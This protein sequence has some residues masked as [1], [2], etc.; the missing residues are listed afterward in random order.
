MNPLPFI[1][2][3]LMISCNSNMKFDSERW[4]HDDITRE[5]RDHMMNDLL[6]NHNL[7]GK[8]QQWVKENLGTPDW[9][10]NYW[11]YETYISYAGLSPDPD[12]ISSLQ[13][14]FDDSATTVINYKLHIWE[15]K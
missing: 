13:L 11:A 15:E 3:L 2:V 14:Y 10:D 8:S 9:T 5:R 12:R 1:A 7:I 6:L 4:K